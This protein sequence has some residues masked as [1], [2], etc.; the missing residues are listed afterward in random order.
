MPDSSLN[1]DRFVK[2]LPIVVL[3]AADQELFYRPTWA[4]WGLLFSIL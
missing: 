4:Y 3:A 1:N 2:Q